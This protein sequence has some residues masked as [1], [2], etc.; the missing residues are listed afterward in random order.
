MNPNSHIRTATAAT[1]S[2]L[3][4]HLPET[5]LALSMLCFLWQR[6]NEGGVVPVCFT[7]AAGYL[8]GNI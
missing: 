7:K 3:Y 8:E 4:L 5:S 2:Y 6:E 1:T